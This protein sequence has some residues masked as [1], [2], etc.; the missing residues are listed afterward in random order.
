M[1]PD[2]KKNSFEFISTPESV[3]SAGAGSVGCGL[4]SEQTVTS[5]HTHNGSVEDNNYW[6]IPGESPELYEA[7]GI[8]WFKKW[9]PSTGDAVRKRFGIEQGGLSEVTGL[10][11]KAEF[12]ID[13]TKKVE[14]FHLGCMAVLGAEQALL[15]G[16]FQGNATA[17]IAY[18]ASFG[19]LQ[20]AVNIYPVMLQRYNRQRA[21]RA[22]GKLRTRSTP[23]E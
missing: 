5:P 11:A 20:T 16:G 22:L 18:H 17:Q 23:T 19:V 6:N 13:A 7:I 15:S 14:A 1:I 21:I 3:I 4:T 12:M 10:Q 8:K 9:M 2:P